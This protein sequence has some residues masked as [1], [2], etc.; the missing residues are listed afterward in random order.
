MGRNGRRNHGGRR[1]ARAMEREGDGTADGWTSS[2][3]DRD[4]ISRF[5]AGPAWDG[6]RLSSGVYSLSTERQRKLSEFERPA[7]WA[8]THSHES[9]RHFDRT[10]GEAPRP[11]AP[12]PNRNAG[13]KCVRKS[14]EIV[15]GRS[16]RSPRSGASSAAP[17]RRPLHS[18]I[19]PGECSGRRLRRAR[20][21]LSHRTRCRR[22]PPAQQADMPSAPSGPAQG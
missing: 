14:G 15:R 21:R 20:R 11:T 5:A 2:A 18:R 7:I 1:V 12:L 22:R 10:Q 19:S 9:S 17:G 16:V 13:R 4:R 3:C 6:P 8:M